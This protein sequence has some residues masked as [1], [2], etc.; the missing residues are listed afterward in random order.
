[1]LRKY[2][3]CACRALA[4]YPRRAQMQKEDH[5]VL[6]WCIF[7]KLCALLLIFYLLGYALGKVVFILLAFYSSDIFWFALFVF[8]FNLPEFEHLFPHFDANWTFKGVPLF[9]IAALTQVFNHADL[10]PSK[11]FLIGLLILLGVSNL[12]FAYSFYAT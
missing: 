9:Q 12:V 1:M 10:G 5:G 7:S 6:L 2:F 3:P 4:R 8:I 11:V